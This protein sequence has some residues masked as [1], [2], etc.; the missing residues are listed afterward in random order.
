MTTGVAVGDPLSSPAARDPMLNSHLGAE[1]WAALIAVGSR[2]RRRLGWRDPQRRLLLHHLE[3]AGDI[4]DHAG[5]IEDTEA[6]P[7]TRNPK[8]AI[9]EEGHV[10]GHDQHCA[11]HRVCDELVL[12]LRHEDGGGSHL[13]PDYQHCDEALRRREGY[14][15][16]FSRATAISDRQSGT[17][18]PLPQLG[19]AGQECLHEKRAWPHQR[20]HL[21]HEGIEALIR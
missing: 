1:L 2:G 11:A 16:H 7:D 19:P 17:F 14:S 3:H 15:G 5:P 20:G 6:C 13:E 10:A 12:L 8:V 9:A 4:L 21:P 18:R